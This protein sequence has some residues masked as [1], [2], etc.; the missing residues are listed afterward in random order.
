MLSV[1]EI[2]MISSDPFNFPIDTDMVGVNVIA[3]KSSTSSS[4][5][6]LVISTHI[7]SLSSNNGVIDNATGMSAVLE[8]ANMLQNVPTN[9]DVT[10]AL[11]SG[12]KN[13][14]YGAR[15]YVSQLTENQ[16]E[17]M[18]NINIDSIGEKGDAYP[19]LG[20][21]DSNP[22][23]MTDLLS[24]YISD[25]TKGG[26]SNYVAFKYANRPAVSIIQSP[27]Y[28]QNSDDEVDINKVAEVTNML[29][30]VALLMN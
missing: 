13:A 25:I 5:N 4:Q 6:N 23:E 28:P 15:Y 7:D 14:S 9:T 2:S 21:T 11:F 10:F 26:M 20:T 27:D 8:L 24:D 18:I 3:K 16:L 17:K 1:Q 30:K 22:N 19:Q 29:Y 12:D